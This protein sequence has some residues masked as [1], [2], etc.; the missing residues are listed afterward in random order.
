VD[1]ITSPYTT[2]IRYVLDILLLIIFFTAS[3]DTVLNIKITGFSIRVCTLVM[4][5][6]SVIVLGISLLKYQK[7]DIRFLGFW[8]F[9]I[10]FLFLL[11]FLP[12]SVLIT[13]GAGY[14]I[15][16]CIFFGFIVALSQYIRDLPY[17]KKILIAYINCFTLIGI[18][19]LIQWALTI[20][21]L[22]M[23]IQFYFKS[24]IPR[25]HGFSYEPSY[26]ST[27]LFIPWVFHFFLYFSAHH[28]LKT[29]V[30]NKTALLILTPV[31]CLSLSRMVIL[32]MLIVLMLR[33]F[34]IIKST[35]I[36]G[37]ILR[38]NLRFLQVMGAGFS[39]VLLIIAFNF[40]KFTTI[41]EG[42][43]IFSRYSHSAT[44]RIGDLLNTWHVFIKSPF[45]GYSLG[46]V[47]PA[48]ARSKGYI[49]ISQ[50]LV[51]NTEGMCI[52]L[53]VLAASGIIGFIFFI[54]FMLK[55]I[56][57][58]RLLQR[59]MK[60]KAATEISSWI[61]VHHL[62]VTAW[63]FQ[64]LLL[65]LNQNI[66]RNYVWIH[67]AIINLSFFIIKARTAGHDNTSAT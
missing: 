20:A 61:S 15:W 43:P 44:I 58:T 39:G 16:L 29:K 7:T 26:F 18:L 56:W 47:A 46:G 3:F 33:L 42:L 9:L 32:L 57:S 37:K 63:L 6:F 34:S 11:V 4:L 45:I 35:L 31:I 21:G 8:S 23:N 30:F 40:K 22:D 49:N 51:K 67:M 10:W 24:G 41:F 36:N 64:L 12:N 19:G 5:I 1:A 17:F 62:L 54:A 60:G 14:M 55:F 13:R 53:E 38:R 59:W 52:F 48:I 28:D 65:C 2:K 66:L 27:Y 25:V 50:E